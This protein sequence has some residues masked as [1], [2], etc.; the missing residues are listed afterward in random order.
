[1]PRSSQQRLLGLIDLVYGCADDP[2]RW[3][4]FVSE[5][6]DELGGAVVSLYLHDH[7]NRRRARIF[8]AGFDPPPEL[9]QGRDASPWLEAYQ[10]APVGEICLHR[11]LPRAEVERTDFYRDV[12]KPL[13]IGSGSLVTLVFDR[14]GGRLGGAL[15]I[16]A[17]ARGRKL[18]ERE[19]ALLRQLAPHI[20]RARELCLRFDRGRARHV[21]LAGVLDL[22]QL[23]VVLLDQDGRPV[24]A[25]QSA[26]ELCGV[27]GA[28]SSASRVDAVSRVFASAL[29]TPIS[30]TRSNGV[31][32]GMIR[33]P[34]DG[35]PI[36]MIV[37]Q[38]EQPASVLGN[39]V[40]AALFLADP[41]RAAG[42]PV[43]VLRALYRL[44]ASESAL[45]VLLVSGLTLK[46]AAHRLSVTEGTARKRL[47][48][49]FDKTKVHSQADLIRVVLAGPGQ[50]RRTRNSD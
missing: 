36:Q 1:M 32:V 14:S 24:F 49:V 40:P 17:A 9:L 4:R 35:A 10:R 15:S 13:G 29:A 18:G 7:G 5:L 42:N 16:T 41:R 19:L 22:L 44:T 39:K 48:G 28:T 27:S 34:V 23:G 50:L 31:E 6:S 2:E 11:F 33:H 45:V 43:D 20:L 38:L 46:G 26:A 47:R 30:G 12:M 37:S 21:G 8:N 25:N 3:G